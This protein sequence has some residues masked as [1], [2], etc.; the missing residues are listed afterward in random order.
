MQDEN[1]SYQ[2]IREGNVV[3]GKIIKKIDGKIYIDINYKTE[4]IIPIEETKRYDFYDKINEGDEIEVM[5]KN[6]DSQEGLVLL[7]KIAVDKR[8]VFSNI[9]KTFREKSYIKGKVIRSIKGGYIVDFGAN[10]TA[11]L[12]MSHTKFFTGDILNK[13]INL[14][15]IQLDEIR[16]N[17]VVSYKDYFIEQQKKEIEEIKKIFPLNEKIKVFVKE[18]KENGIL[19]T[20]ENKEAFIPDF[21]IRWNIYERFAEKFKVGEETEAIVINNN[22]PDKLLLSIKKLKENPYKKFIETNKPGEKIDVKIKEIMV[23]KIIVSIS[24]EMVGIVPLTEISYLKRIN[25]I[26]DLYKIGEELK[27]VILKY[28]EQANIIFLSIKRCFENPWR[29][30][31]ERYP[32]GARVIGS[33]KRIIEGHGVEVELEE[34]IDAFVSIKDISWFNFNKIEEVVKTGEKK[35]FKIL[36]IDKNKFRL[37]LG[38]KQLTT[39]PWNSFLNK[40]KEGTLIDVKIQDFENAEMICQIIEGVNGKL[41]LKIKNISFKKGD[42]IKA[43]I[44]KIDKENKKVFLTLPESE[45]TEEKKQLD[46]YIK[47]HEHSFKMNDIIN[48]ENVNKEDKK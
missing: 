29:K 44:T 1:I 10:I 6:T 4:G 43:K 41:P 11:F 40:Y 32:V 7:S 18:I 33:I 3:K 47:T 21:E 8:N 39:N 9:K 2:S 25:N 27:T 24:E 17:I 22:L 28:D 26:S 46:E 12:P 42:I 38:L 37:I 14:K 23:D 35:E 13:E 20:K 15:I 34:N 19:V 16:K 45:K 48:F 30:I 31:E 5:I 36:E